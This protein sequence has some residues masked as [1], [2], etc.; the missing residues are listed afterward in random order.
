LSLP[1]AAIVFIALVTA[2]AA[3]GSDDS[4][5]ANACGAVVVADVWSR[6]AQLL[7]GDGHVYD[8]SATSEEDESARTIGVVYL[9]LKNDGSVDERLISAS[10]DVAMT[11]E[12]HAVNMV[13]GVMQMRQ[14]VDGIELPAGETVRFEPGGLHIMLIGL[15]RALEPGDEFSVSLTFEHAAELTVRAE[16]R[17][18]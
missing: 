3:C 8:A 16:V 15:T 17:D 12:L 4:D 7:D 11:A 2:L 18:Q 6:P 1:L 10:S 14:A 9:T 13:D 5:A